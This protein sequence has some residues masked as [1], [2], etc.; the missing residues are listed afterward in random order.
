MPIQPQSNPTMEVDHFVADACPQCI[1]L[2][3]YAEY[4]KSTERNSKTI[5][6]MKVLILLY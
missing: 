5:D 1:R 4:G 2:R 3:N 6:Y